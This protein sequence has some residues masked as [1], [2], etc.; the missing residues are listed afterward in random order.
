MKQF[1]QTE[2]RH[3]P[4]PF[5]MSAKQPAWVKYQTLIRLLKR[6]PDDPEVVRWRKERDASP[7]VKR[8][9]AQQSRQGCFHSMPWLHVHE[10]PLH[11]MLDMGY[12]LE[13][14]TIRR[15]V[16]N[17]LDYQLPDG[18]YMHPAGQKVNT[19][20]PG[21]GW[22]PCVTGYVTKALMDLGLVSHP[23]VKASLDVMYSGQREN[24]GWICR[25]VGQRAPYC[26]L[27]G[28]PWVFACLVQ[29]RLITR[30]SGITKRALSV[31]CD[32]KEKI[33]R[34]GYQMDRCYRCD[35][36]LL[37]PW[38]HKV[39]VSHRHYLFRDLRR[40]LLNKQREDGAWPFGGR[41]PVKR[42]AWYT[43]ES[44]AALQAVH[45]SRPR[46]PDASAD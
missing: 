33:V 45:V 34:H 43:I 24:G 4:I 42:S 14:K 22:A 32:H 30:R 36:A 9:R 44:V 8:I 2:L 26:I 27:S 28:T 6:P 38:L 23:K 19:P 35:E 39:G 5:L 11:R 1:A 18:G 17:L 41:R 20:N 3:D 12:G 16:D 40:S 10:Y 25:H 13:D 46:Q 21:I 15:T 29:A 37:L 31:F 7:L